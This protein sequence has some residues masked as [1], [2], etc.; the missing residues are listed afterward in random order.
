[1][2]RITVEPLP[3]GRDCGAVVV[4]ARELQ[5]PLV[6][7]T[8]SDFLVGGEADVEDKARD[9]FN[10]LSC[11]SRLIYFFDEIDELILVLLRQVCVNALSRSRVSEDALRRDDRGQRA[12]ADHRYRRA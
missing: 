12:R 5:W 8:P 6:M 9:I 10:A 2:P 11:G 3:G 4:M 1:M 7:L